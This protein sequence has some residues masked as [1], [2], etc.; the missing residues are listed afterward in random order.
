MFA[1]VIRYTAGMV[2]FNEELDKWLQLR[3]TVMKIAP[4][5]MTTHVNNHLTDNN[6]VIFERDQQQ[7]QLRTETDSGTPVTAPSLDN[8]P[9]G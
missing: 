7:Q 5:S 1:Y 4:V 3:Q 6:E 9:V 8:I 2:W